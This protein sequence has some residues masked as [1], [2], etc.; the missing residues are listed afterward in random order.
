MNF[1]IPIA[2]SLLCGVTTVVEAQREKRNVDY[3]NPFIG[4]EVVRPIV[5]GNTFPGAC[6]PFGMVQLSPDT[7]RRIKDG[8]DYLPSGYD[9]KRDSISDFSFTHLNG[10]GAQDLYDLMMMPSTEASDSL[11][12]RLWYATPFDHGSEKAK[13]GFYEVRLLNGIEIELTATCHTGMMRVRYPEGKPQSLVIDLSYSEKN[14]WKGSHGCID[15]RVEM[16]NDSTLCGYRMVDGWQRCRKVAFYIQFS[17]PIRHWMTK[18]FGF[19][20]DSTRI[21]TGPDT[22]VCLDFGHSTQPLLIKTALSPL[23]EACLLYTSPS[24]RD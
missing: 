9:H 14:Y 20:T 21:V 7:K 18:G 2:L 4:T 8:Y 12:N 24:P 13:A 17:R 10:A 3:V 23:S 1:K 15:A 11:M 5:C 22:K 6:Y 16:V 19:V